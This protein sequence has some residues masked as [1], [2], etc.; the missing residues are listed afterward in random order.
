[1]GKRK[2]SIIHHDSLMILDE[3][4][5]EEAGKLFK[6]I[7]NFI[8]EGVEPEDKITRLV[9]NPFRN[10]LIRDAEK[11]AETCANRASS[12][13]VGGKQKVANASNAKQKVAN[14]ADSKSKSKSKSKS[15]SKNKSKVIEPPTREEVINYFV[16]KGYT[17]EAGGKA[18]DYYHNLDWKDSNGKPV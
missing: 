2:S 17:A 5:D 8:I 16:K 4:S 6:S 7:K 9:F 15:N 12:G 14:L 11:Y 1:M 3:L 18:F 13:S 10:Q